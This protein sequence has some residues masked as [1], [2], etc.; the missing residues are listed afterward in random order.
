MEKR[1]LEQRKIDRIRS[2][3]KTRQDAYL[4]SVIEAKLQECQQRY[5]EEDQPENEET[6]IRN[7][8]ESRDC[9]NETMEEEND[10]FQ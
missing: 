5:F 10:L 6:L 7:C 2:I 3:E 4:N 8:Q 9:Y 1:T